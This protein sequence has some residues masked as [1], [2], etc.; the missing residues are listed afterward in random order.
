MV[1]SFLALL[2]IAA[3][4]YGAANEIDVA[5]RVDTLGDGRAF[6]TSNPIHSYRSGNPHDHTFF[7][8]VRKLVP[9]STVTGLS[10]SYSYITGF[11]SGV[12]SNFSV[13]VAGT[14]VYSSPHLTDY[15]YA[16]NR[17]NYSKPVPVHVHGVS[18]QVPANA[19]SYVA[20]EFDNN[21]RNIQ[22]ALPMLFDVECAPGTPCVMPDAPDVRTPTNVFASGE[23]DENGTA[24]GCYRIPAV[25]KHK[26]TILAFAE[27]RYHGCRPD[28]FPTTSVAVRW[29]LDGI[30]EPRSESH[31]RAHPRTFGMT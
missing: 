2:G 16:H 1:A 10:F 9:G 21:D 14:V 20:I 31:P 25:V 11:S 5:C 18:I 22:L 8:L 28:V 30:G 13:S 3:N 7:K 29:S 27:A 24:V 15:M 4:A 6:E 26:G 23:I 17:S 12:G 19:T